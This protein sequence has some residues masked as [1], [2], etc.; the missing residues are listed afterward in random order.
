MNGYFCDMT[1]ALA[2]ALAGVAA[3]VDYVRDVKP[4]F[5][6]NCCRCHGASQHKGGL[7]LD[8]AA[9]ALKGGETGPAFKSGKSAESLIVQA[10]KGTHPEIPRMPYKKRALSDAQIVMI[11]QWIDQGAPCRARRQARPR[12]ALRLR[13][14]A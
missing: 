13:R 3:P 9:F 6:E 8:T 5:A 12:A 7:R 4:I 11:E 2:I 1:L 14:A 10:I